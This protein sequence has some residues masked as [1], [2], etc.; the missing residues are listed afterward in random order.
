MSTV[1]VPDLVVDAC[2][3]V[4]LTLARSRGCRMATADR[5]FFDEMVARGDAADLIWV[6]DPI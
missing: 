2:L 1:A 3:A 5:A 6:T 4:K